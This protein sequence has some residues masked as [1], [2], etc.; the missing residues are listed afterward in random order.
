MKQCKT[1]PEWY[2]GLSVNNTPTEFQAFLATQHDDSN[3]KKCPIPCNDTAIEQVEK[4]RKIQ[5]SCY[6]ATKNA[7]P[8]CYKA[9]VWVATAGYKDPK[10][11]KN[12]VGI[13]PKSSFEDVQ[14]RLAKN[15]DKK[16][17]CDHMPCPCHTAVSG[18]KCRDSV[19]WVLKTRTR[20]PGAIT[21]RALA[22]L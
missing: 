7:N 12:Y 9:V 2:A 14:A 11:K 3:K 21:C 20:S 15:K 13:S 4:L 10:L 22:T 6:T 18:E 16:S 1:H 8:I 19:K 17:R 5:G